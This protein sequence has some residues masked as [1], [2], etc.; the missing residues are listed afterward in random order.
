M[1]V[2]ISGSLIFKL[3]VIIMATSLNNNIVNNN[4][5]AVAQILVEPLWDMRSQC[6]VDTTQGIHLQ[7]TSKGT[8]ILQ[9]NSANGTHVQIQIPGRTETQIESF[10]SDLYI[11]RDGDVENCL[12]KYVVFSEQLETC[13]S[14]IIGTNIKV[15]LHG[16]VSLFFQAVPAIG[17]LSK[18]YGE[19]EYLQT[20]GNVSQVSDCSNVTEYNEIVSCPVSSSECRIK[21]PPNCGAILG[22]G[23]V[24]YKQCS[25]NV[26]ENHTALMLIRTEVLDLSDNNIIK[27]GDRTFEGVATVTDLD[28]SRN[29]L[30]TLNADAMLGLTNLKF[31]KFDSNQISVLHTESFLQLVNLKRL[32]FTSNILN[33]LPEHIFQNLNKLSALELDENQIMEVNADV[34]QGLGKLKKLKLNGNLLRVLL[35]GVFKYLSNLEDLFLHQNN[36]EYLGSEVFFGLRNLKELKL[37]FNLLSSLPKGIFQELSNLEILLLQDN[38]ITFLNAEVF[39]GLSKLKELRMSKNALNE[40][41]N[42]LFQD[43]PQ[44]EILLI[45]N[46]TFEH[47]SSGTFNGLEKIQ[48]LLVQSNKLHSLDSG[49]FHGLIS[50]EVISLSFNNLTSLPNDIFQGLINLR[51]LSVEENELVQVGNNIFDGLTNLYHLTLSNNRLTRLSYDVFKDN[52]KLSFLDLSGNLLNSIPNI[53]HLI[54]LDILSMTNNNLLFIYN[55]SFYSLSN[56]SSIYVSQHEVCQCYVPSNVNCSA[57]NDRSPYLT[58]NRLLSDRALVVVM[59]LIGL[60]AL[61]GNL[62][63][64]VSRNRGTRKKNVNSFLLRNLAASDLL[65]GIYMLTLACADIYFGDNFPMQ[66]ESWRSGITCRVV[67]AMSIIS[68]EASVFFVT[69]ISIDRFI[70]IRYPYSTNK[71]GKYSVKFVAIVVWTVSLALGIVPSVL[72]GFNFKFYDNS[73]VCIGLPLSLTKTYVTEKSSHT[74][75]FQ[76][77]EAGI[78]AHYTSFTTEYKGLINGLFFSTALFLGLNCICYLVIL[79]CYFEIVTAVRKSSK[80]AGRSPEMT[81][82][83]KLTMKVTTIVA[84]DF[85]CW[86]PVIIL[87]ILVQ[88]RVIE[89]PPSVYAW[90]VTF[91]LPINSAINP[92]LYTIAEVL[93]GYRKKLQRKNESLRTISSKV[94]TAK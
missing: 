4:I 49:L 77:E 33:T 68:S 66:S 7:G 50:L 41:P 80:R 28:L 56:I 71:L 40:L 63:V 69:V 73:H 13:N 15:T 20:R 17:T 61:S 38:K 65:M 2:D 21:F 79:A 22:P 12:S 11:E 58:C 42:G 51:Y 32:F 26:S 30:S 9:V 72:S 84:T 45:N 14:I 64:L 75:V 52:G 1:A 19:N 47:F 39:K 70:A 48:A 35:D 82:Q 81:E 43:L 74:R 89:L 86:F 31:L 78:R 94:T 37:S 3:C 76:F 60:G 16:K 67:G 29:K 23:E 46:N 24:T 5:L 54:H 59:W 85:F 90:C 44:L 8:C 92:Y 6:S 55:T 57:E 18:C 10:P 62:F 25:Y 93:S 27:I 91:V 34:F 88:L 87:G 36:I 53:V 83:I